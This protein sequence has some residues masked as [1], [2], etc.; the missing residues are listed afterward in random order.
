MDRD[1]YEAIAREK[2]LKLRSLL[3]GRAM[4]CETQSCRMD[5]PNRAVSIGKPRNV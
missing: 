2:G 3:G 4:G 5:I 1:L